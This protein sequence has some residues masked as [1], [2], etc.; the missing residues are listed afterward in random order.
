LLP[1]LGKLNID[2]VTKKTPL[3]SKLDFFQAG[4]NAI[5]WGHGIKI[6]PGY[7]KIAPKLDF[8]DFR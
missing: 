1:K 4:L 3:F 8:L 5:F 7:V 6:W 2:S